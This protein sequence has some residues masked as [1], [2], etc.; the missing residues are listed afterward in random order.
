MNS[1]LNKFSSLV[2]NPGDMVQFWKKSEIFSVKGN[3]NDEGDTISESGNNKS[4]EIKS[5]L[6]SAICLIL[7]I[8]LLLQSTLLVCKKNNYQT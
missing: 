1:I 4:E 5:E 7:S 8:Y 3:K 2:A 6:M